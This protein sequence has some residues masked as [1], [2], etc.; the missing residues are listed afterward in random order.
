MKKQ[1]RSNERTTEYTVECRSGGKLIERLSASSLASAA[2]AT[3]RTVTELLQ[4]N[5]YR[6]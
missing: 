2:Q 5:G 6:G 3:G 1:P 4:D